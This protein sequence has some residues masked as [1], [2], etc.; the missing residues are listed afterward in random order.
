MSR[1]QVLGGLAL[2]ALAGSGWAQT[3]P[4]LLTPPPGSLCPAP[5]VSTEPGNVHMFPGRWWNPQRNGIGWDFF[6]GEGQ[7]TMYLTWFTYDQ[8]G[9]PV[10]LHGENKGLTFNGVTGER[11]W[12]SSLYVA[13]WTF[14]T[15]GRTFTRVGAVS[16]TFPNQTTTRAAV[17]WRWD[18]NSSITAVGAS[19]YDEC[20]YDTFRDQRAMRY[21]ES[22]INE[23]FSSNWFYRGIEG[24]PLVGW[25]VDLLIDINPAN[26]HYFET[27]SAAIF[28][29]SGRPVWLQS[30]DEW[31]TT[32]PADD[33]MNESTRGVLRYLKFTTV[34]NVHPAVTVCAEAS[35][36]CGPDADHEGTS[37]PDAY[38]RFGRR[39]DNAAY[40]R[41]LLTA[42]VPAGVTGGSAVDWPPPNNVPTLP[43]DVPVMRFDSNH[44]IVD[45]TVCRVPG[46]NDTCT[47]QVSWS[48]NDPNAKIVR[49]DL[50]NG[51]T[52]AVDFAEGL[53][54]VKPDPLPVGA[55]VQYEIHYHYNGTGP[56]TKLRTPEVR[57][58]R[59]NTIADANVE[60]IACT[61][62]GNNGCDLPV[63]D[64]R[65]GAIAGEGTT[66]GGAAQYAIPIAVPPGRNGVEP[67]L[68]LNYNS[69]SGGG[70]AGLGWSLSGLSAIHR[71]PKTTAQDG[72]GAD[73]I[74]K[75]APVTM[76]ASDALCLDG[77]RLVRTNV[78]G[79]LAPNEPYGVVGA[80]YRTEI[81][82]FARVTQYG[83]DL[84]SGASCF[85][86]EHK[87]GE[88]SYYGGVSDGGT[89]SGGGSRH[90]PYVDNVPEGNR[91][92]LS[93][94]IEREQDP[95]GNSITYTYHASEPPYGNGEKLL[96]YIRYTGTG[97][98]E[99][100]RQVSF[101]YAMRPDADRSRSYLAGG[102]TERTRRL[103]R[104]VTS[105]A[106]ASVNSYTLNYA[107]PISGAPGN[108]H[109]GHSALQSIRQCASGGEET[110]G[111]GAFGA[112]VCLPE[113]VVSWNDLP[114]DHV[115][116]PVTIA[117][118]PDPAPDSNGG[119]VDRRVQTIGDLDGDGVREVL[120]NQRQSDNVV[121]TW[122][123]K[124]N[125]DRVV[126]STL[127]ITSIAGS[128]L[129][130]TQGMQTDYDG[131]GRADLVAADEG[132]YVRLYRWNLTRGANFGATPAA[133]FT[134]VTLNGVAP[135]H[136]L[137]SSDDIDGDGQADLILRRLGSS[138]SSLAIDDTP[139]NAPQSYDHILCYY[140]NTTSSPTAVNFATGVQIY[141]WTHDTLEGGLSPVGDF[142]GD[143]TSDLVIM[144]KTTQPGGEVDAVTTVLLS[145]QPG[146]QL[147]AGCTATSSAHWK[148]CTA[149]A[150]GLPTNDTGYRTTGATMRWHDVNGDGLTD[151][152]YAVPCS[153]TNQNCARGS[154]HVHIANGRG[155]NA[156]VGIA[157][158]T[159]AL[160]M[161]KGMAKNRLRY[162]A[163]L[164]A[165]D[166]DSDGKLDL[167]YP[168]GLAAR[169]CMSVR[170]DHTAQSGD[171]CPYD[172]ATGGRESGLTEQ[173]QT[174]VWVCGNDPAVD[175]VGGTSQYGLPD[176][177]DMPEQPLDPAITSDNLY[178][179]RTRNASFTATDQ[180]L[181]YMAGLRFVATESGYEAQSFSLNASAGTN[182]AAHRVA[183]TLNDTTSLN[184]A[185]DL[186]GDGL[187]DLM[188]RVGC[189]NAGINDDLCHFVSDG[190][191]GPATVATGPTPNAAPVSVNVGTFN[192]GL[193]S[194]VNENVGVGENGNSAP[195]LPNTVRMITNGLGDRVSWTYYPLSSKAYRT[196][197]QLP[198][199]YLP[200]NG[201][202]DS[203][204]FYFQSTMPVVGSMASNSGAG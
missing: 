83:G 113:T 162:A 92:P 67:K 10:W 94:N 20:L 120:V 201:Y 91:V 33:T 70:I 28:D 79:T 3:S 109:S 182:R 114:P 16:V 141:G 44:V 130:F 51:G 59:E 119:F 186:Y 200:E 25:G 155:F 108:L 5:T 117:G 105:V 136:Q 125:A 73:G 69:R 102:V 195:L 38:G 173:C 18:V 137:V 98:T 19:T 110:T 76:T 203:N 31:G 181:Y 93:W 163:Q 34:P 106:G 116:R 72:M 192:D 139:P 88:V 37:E 4:T 68:G 150:M 178:T 172:P 1:R 152:L 35:S 50:N 8:Q 174:R 202:V 177:A 57:V 175:I 198:L 95:R 196:A 22:V 153:T 80:Y 12:Q 128:V 157:G 160:L 14:G 167:L 41:V 188:T 204:H 140:R 118:L 145:Q 129:Y 149:G 75:A 135:G 53:S 104:I 87:S 127:D 100:N 142:N 143:G 171:G 64:A 180:S 147:P 168:V 179:V 144:T 7:Q 165:A 107:D 132:A 159:D 43:N 99:G 101:E 156:S 49:Y 13:Q 45:K 169:Q 131:D 27:A 85:K 66:D 47:F 65:T 184:T 63:H 52:T 166:V 185:E 133:T 199:H 123:V 82:N 32:P 176:V 96:Q 11:T 191:S 189:Y 170:V 183:M 55:R 40:G 112:E 77:Q 60:N 126:T 134:T 103:H 78:S 187:T 30:V 58:L 46:A 97:S 9:R 124:Q 115:L 15:Q 138:C 158:N 21:S 197:G 81:N 24:D 2:L 89:C 190:V 6:Y 26:S 121:H 151:L 61:P 48:T 56:L 161:T 23:A 39:I 62:Q 164:P 86:V 84:A 36:V 146:A 17:R 54:D 154:W 90:K 148:Q 111:P 122:L 71:C 29:T 74:S 193:R 42:D 194:Y